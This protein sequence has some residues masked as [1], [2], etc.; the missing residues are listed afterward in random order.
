MWGKI[1]KWTIFL[2]LQP[3]EKYIL[4]CRNLKQYLNLGL[5][6][7]KGQRVLKFKQLPWLKESIDMV[8]QFRQYANNKFEVNLY[9]LMNDS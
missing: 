2:A 6:M 1:Q 4:H 5:K 7:S 8:T 9:M 3:K